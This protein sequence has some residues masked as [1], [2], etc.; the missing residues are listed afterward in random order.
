LLSEFPYKAHAHIY[1][2]V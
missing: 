1:L 2:T